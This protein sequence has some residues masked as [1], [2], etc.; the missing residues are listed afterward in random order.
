MKRITHKI[1]TYLLMTSLI[2]IIT[3]SGANGQE[4]TFRQ[5]AWRYGINGALQ[6]NSA[7]LG[8]QQLHNLEGN[9]HSPADDVKL[10]D[11]TGI[12]IYGGLFGE[13]L[14]DSWWGRWSRAKVD[15]YRS[16]R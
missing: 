5:Q 11:G 2:V 12:G 9:F 6:F 1:I 14:S 16:E 3:Y 4:S 10:V 8:W 13:Y 15:G 7:C